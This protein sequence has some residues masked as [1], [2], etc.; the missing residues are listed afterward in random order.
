M[1]LSPHFTLP[2]P[3]TFMTSRHGLPLPGVRE[4]FPDLF[5]PRSMTTPQTPPSA[6]HDQQRTTYDM[7]NLP[8]VL[9]PRHLQPAPSHRPTAQNTATRTADHPYTRARFNSPAPSSS[10]SQPHGTQQWPNPDVVAST[11]TPHVSPTC[12]SP[13]VSSPYSQPHP[14]RVERWEV[15]QSGTV[16]D[17]EQPSSPMT[18]PSQM[19][20]NLA[21]FAPQH[22]SFEQKSVETHSGKKRHKCDVCGSYW[23][24]PS[25]L[26]IHMNLCVPSA[27]KTLGSSQII[28]D[29]SV[30]TTRI[31]VKGSRPGSLVGGGVG[32]VG[33]RTVD[34]YDSLMK[35]PGSKG[36]DTTYY[37]Q[38]LTVF[39]GVVNCFTYS[40]SVLCYRPLIGSW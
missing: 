36:S 26:K 14:Q 27:S 20:S 10:H 29:T 8:P 30:S 32:P 2:S 25:S 3:C 21:E 39:R 13:E 18:P 38:V 1:P 17:D 23:G 31:R 12:T 6:T 4:L 19:A 37:V 7:T 34:P 16:H 11:H 24:R 28:P 9:T 5:R 40:L 33:I 35:G 22:S 15:G